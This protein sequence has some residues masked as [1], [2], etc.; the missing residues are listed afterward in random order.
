M[1]AHKDRVAIAR[2][3]RLVTTSE[4]GRQPLD[5]NAAS[6]AYRSLHTPPEGW[7]GWDDDR[8]DCAGAA[9]LAGHAKPRRKTT[10][11]Q[12]VET[13]RALLEHAVPGLTLGDLA[14]RIGVTEKS[15]YTMRSRWPD[16]AAELDRRRG[17]E[18]DPSTRASRMRAAQGRVTRARILQVCSPGMTLS[19]VA[20]RVGLTRDSVRYHRREHPA[21]RRA[22]DAALA[23]TREGVR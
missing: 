23:G 12:G 15:M 16:W 14:R 1:S 2:L 6:I 5:I 9:M 22:M 3:Y 8:D 10:A 18:S 11:E 4:P 17:F 19:D 13:R 20:A 7:Y 21:F